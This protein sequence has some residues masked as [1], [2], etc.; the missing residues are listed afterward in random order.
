MRECLHA[1]TLTQ[2][3][4]KGTK[5]SKSHNSAKAEK[6]KKIKISSSKLGLRTKFLP[7]EKTD[8]QVQLKTQGI[9]TAPEVTPLTIPVFVTVAILGLLLSHMPPEE[10]ES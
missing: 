4:E 1:L 2:Q 7:F 3:P 6:P 9:V 8:Y 5:K 10:G